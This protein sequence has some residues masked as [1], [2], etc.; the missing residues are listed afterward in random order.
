MSYKESKYNLILFALSL[1]LAFSILSQSITWALIFFVIILL[2][3]IFKKTIT[4]WF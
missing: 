1:A 3:F 2:S 4:K